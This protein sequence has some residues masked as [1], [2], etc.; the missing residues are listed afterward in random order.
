VGFGAILALILPLLTKLPGAAGEYFKQ[1]QEVQLEELRTQRAIEA[2]KQQLAG[3]LAKAQL[4][5]NRAIVSAT[6]AK[7]KY[8]TFIMWFGPFMVGTVWPAKANDI[9]LNWASMPNW[10]VQSCMLIMFTVWGISTSAPAVANIFSSLTQYMSN[11]KDA[12]RSFELA[13]AEINRKAV[14]DT[15]KAKWFPKGM[16]QQQV[17]DLDEAIDNGEK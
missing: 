7:F 6:G 10:Y 9:F 13:K 2:S 12:K 1:K 8:F 4:E 15:V 16:N 3:E 11:R 17:N 14:F 5:L